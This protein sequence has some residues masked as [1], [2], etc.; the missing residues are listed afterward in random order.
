V[1]KLCTHHTFRYVPPK[2]N[3]EEE[4]EPSEFV[5]AAKSGNR[6]F[7]VVNRSV[8]NWLVGIHFYRCGGG[9][10]GL[11]GDPL[12]EIFDSMAGI[13]DAVAGM[14]EFAVQSLEG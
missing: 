4:T 9:F 13:A 8:V 1:T 5:V 7:N 6:D 10:L 14:S 12:F 3:Q 11:R 2:E